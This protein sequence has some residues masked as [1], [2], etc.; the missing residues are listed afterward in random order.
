MVDVLAQMAIAKLSSQTSSLCIERLFARLVQHCC[1]DRFPKIS[2]IN[3]EGR[4]YC[5]AF[6]KLK[7]AEAI[8]KMPFNEKRR[9]LIRRLDDLYPGNACPEHP[10][11]DDVIDGDELVDILTVS[12]SIFLK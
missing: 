10:Q 9:E 8:N 11:M 1:G 5:L 7:L 12:Y 4:L 3:D 6:N 2:T